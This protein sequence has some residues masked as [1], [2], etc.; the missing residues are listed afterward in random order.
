MSLP[1][2][3][4]FKVLVL[5]AGFVSGPVLEYLTSYS[6]TAVTVAS[7]QQSEVTSLSGKFSNTN[8]IL[9][10]AG[11]EKERLSELI[12]GHDL[13]V[14]L[15]PYAMHPSIAEFCVQHKK[16]M[17][18]A[19]Y[20][21]D[22]M[23]QFQ[24][25]AIDAGITI[26]ME[27]GV[28]PGV[29][30]MLAMQ[31]FDDIKKNGGEVS[32]FVSWCGGLPA[33][34][35]SDNPLRYKFSWS[36]LGALLVILAPSRYL[37]NGEIVERAAGGENYRQ[38][39]HEIN[40]FPAFNLE[41]LPNRDS[42][43]YAKEYN[44]ENVETIL[45]GTLRYKGFAEVVKG[46]LQIGLIDLEPNPLLARNAP[47]ITWKQLIPKLIGDRRD[48]L[49]DDD[50]HT[51]VYDQV[52]QEISRL[53]SIK[54]LGLL[55]DCPVAKAGSPLKALAEHLSS[56]LAYGTDERDMIIMR[57]EIEGK[58]SDRTEQHNINLVIYGEPSG[59]TAM[60]KGVGFPCA[61]AARMI[62]KGQIPERGIVTPL[63]PHVYGPILDKL[64]RM[65]VKAMSDLKVERF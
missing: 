34:E 59:F 10:D 2:G 20:V 58:F 46:L 38:P 9:M 24:D 62:L 7:D 49:S 64:R 37:V 14:S 16:N 63:Q 47:D 19:S 45:R 26:G 48:N 41:G 42:I 65:G 30:H 25:R 53:K 60:S 8:P 40:G 6:D 52:D 39:T 36:P 22:E 17:V 33:P 50:L 44:I 13:T 23:N 5:G 28:D 18:T 56:K 51:A 11:N 57:H 54:E 15:L 32:S 3:K 31:C 1:M 27:F 12:K 29:D 55:S 21:T 43:K 61:I 4:K 35:N